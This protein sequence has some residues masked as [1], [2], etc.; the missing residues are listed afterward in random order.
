MLV[1]QT[2]FYQ[3]KIQ[4]LVTNTHRNLK[5]IKPILSQIYY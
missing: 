1:K 2:P 3:E 5:K 4:S